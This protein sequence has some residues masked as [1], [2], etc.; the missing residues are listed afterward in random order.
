M[1][2]FDYISGVRKR[3][4]FNT[5]YMGVWAYSCEIH[6]FLFDNITTIE[7]NLGPCCGCCCCCLFYMCLHA[8]ITME[9]NAQM[10]TG[11][12]CLSIVC[13]EWQSGKRFE[14]FHREFDRSESKKKKSTRKNLMNIS[15]NWNSQ[16]EKEFKMRSI[17][18]WTRREKNQVA[19]SN[20]TNSTIYIRIVWQTK[21]K[22]DLF[23]V[24]WHKSQNND[25]AKKLYDING[26]AHRDL[27]IIHL[28]WQATFTGWSSYSIAREREKNGSMSTKVHWIL[29]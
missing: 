21:I 27:P 15:R 16:R 26:S 22:H 2:T 29:R 28:M 17:S 19:R 9:T 20:T 12:L 1:Q 5:I 18:D 23:K 6:I 10:L 13:I 25:N 8:R 24:P 7:F 14:G 4:R 3:H 11:S